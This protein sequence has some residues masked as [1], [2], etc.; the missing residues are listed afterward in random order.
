M[1]CFIE[2]KRKL[3]CVWQ[4]LIVV[5]LN[6]IL[7][8][9]GELC[10]SAEK[11]PGQEQSDLATR[12]ENIMRR[13]EFQNGRWG[14]K[15]YD[16]STKQIIYSL[17]SDQLFNPASSMKVFVEGTAFDALGTDYLF[18][19]RVYRTGPVARGVLKGDLVLVA[20]GDLLLGGR[21][22]PDGSLALPHPDH[23]YSDTGNAVPVSDDPLRSIRQLAFQVAAHGIRRIE[24]RVL[25]D[26]S[27]FPETKD[28]GGNGEITVSP[29]MI[30][31][32]LI[33]VT[34]TPGPQEGEPA[35]LHISP[36]TAYLKIINQ[37]ITM[38]ASEPPPPPRSPGSLQ[39]VDDTTSADGTHTIVLTG[40]IP[41]GS[42]PILT[43]YRIPEPARFAE[44]ALAEELRKIWIS[45][46][47]DL[48]ANPDFH[49]LSRFY[50]PKNMVA[51]IVPPPLSDQVKPM[52][53]L[54]SNPHTITFPYL[55]GAIA[56]HDSEN[57]KRTG[58]EFQQRLFERAGVDL[59]GWDPE[60]GTFTPD[61]FTKFLTYM[62]Q[63]PYFPI[64]RN[65]LPILGV[66][67]PLD[68]PAA[69]HIYA[70]GGGAMRTDPA[71]TM[72]QQIAALDGFIELPDGRFIVFATFLEINGQG[73]VDSA[74]LTGVMG[75][76]ASVVYESLLQQ[77]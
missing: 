67:E 7:L 36:E 38:A 59:N 69:G 24:G 8:I 40:N 57:A 75:E 44:V 43:T 2:R 33:D 11:T 20:G 61:F 70:K 17:N 45:S 22:L 14:M 76:I 39:F 35:K 27:L 10:V 25:V 66:D 55:V 23:S 15:F 50:T 52:L 53:K 29:M 65:D 34:V 9:G 37:T 28:T 63:Q 47:V 1:K 46:E 12:I 60:N 49:A 41:Q 48:L 31:D 74:K 26:A 64:Y 42:R 68:S 6:A 19:T 4:R 3:P 21:V 71:T 18:R 51:R 30:N 54:S 62:M 16:P 32:N 77:P 73:Q 56:G 72:T 13:P 5:C 58:L